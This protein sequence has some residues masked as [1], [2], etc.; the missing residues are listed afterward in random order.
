[1]RLFKGQMLLFWGLVLSTVIPMIGLFTIQSP[2]HL[3][4]VFA[5]SGG[6]GAF[7]FIRYLDGK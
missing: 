4:F 3:L 5:L 7:T 2:I 1:M 6:A